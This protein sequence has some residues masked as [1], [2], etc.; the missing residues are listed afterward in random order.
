MVKAITHIIKNDGD[1]AA[2]IGQNEAGDTVKVYPMIATQKEA[3]PLVSVW[4]TGRKPEF[5]RGQRP[6]TFNYTYEVHVY[7]G[8]YDEAEA[9]MAAIINALEETNISPVINGVKFTDRV[10]NV[11]SFDKG[12]IEE[13][14]A[15]NRIGVFEAP[16]NEDQAS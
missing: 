6:T 2:L 10:R 16:V 13:Y 7:S 8:D 5:C 11:D 9:I 3:L 14:K 4:M 1:C 15:Y 12:Y